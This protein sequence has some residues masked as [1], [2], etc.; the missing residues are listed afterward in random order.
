MV[1]FFPPLRPTISAALRDVTSENRRARAAA[2]ESLGGAGEDRADEA[3]AALRPL[4]DDVAAA[5]RCSAIASLGHLA[6]REALDDIVSRFDDLDPTVRQVALISAAEIGDSSIAPALKR[7]LKR[8]DPGVRF[9][10]IASLATLIGEAAIEPLSAMLED[11]DAEVRAHLADV[12][13]SL[14]SKR[15]IKSLS[16]LLADPER[17]VRE[18]A[19]VALARCGDDSGAE[20]LILL[21]TDRDRCFEAAWALG[22]LRIV[23]AAD[24]LARL[25]TA[26]LKPLAVK[27]A[28]AA[29]LIRIGDPRG[30]PALRSVLRA[31]RSDARG[32]AAELVGELGLVSLAPELAKLA[33]RPRGADRV[34]IAEA[35]AKLQGESPEART[36]LEHLSARSD[37]AGA[38]A[39]ELLGDT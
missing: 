3:K 38:R 20:E 18:S 29:A 39:R 32:Y 26:L 13:G 2:A 28:A 9:Q 37:E 7:A 27:A 35:L 5:V 30:E 24:P 4:I 6:D 15:G 12:L 11:S 19:S 34:V 21:L 16:R 10:A 17:R 1:Q 33:R 25:A 23:N 8:D 36:A 31:V 22:E 14:E